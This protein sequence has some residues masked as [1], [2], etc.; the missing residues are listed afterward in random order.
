MPDLVER[1]R[2][3]S[4]GMRYRKPPSR[5]IGEPQ[6]KESVRSKCKTTFGTC[7]SSLRLRK[8]ASTTT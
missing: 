3:S 7:R 5:L 1:F 2:V 4:H 6:P 8:P